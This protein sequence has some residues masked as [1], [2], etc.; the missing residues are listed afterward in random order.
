MEIAKHLVMDDPVAVGG[1]LC[2]VEHLVV[3]NEIVG[4]A[5]FACVDGDLHVVS[6]VVFIVAGMDSLVIDVDED[7]LMKHYVQFVLVSEHANWMI[8]ILFFDSMM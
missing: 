5:S 2:V 8:D 6:D 3:S 7:F 1:E 4:I